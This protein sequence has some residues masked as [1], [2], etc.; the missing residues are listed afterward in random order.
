MLTVT[1]AL[2]TQPSPGGEELER[3]LLQIAQD[4]RQALGELYRLTRGAV[5][6]LALSWLKNAQEAQDVTQ[7]VFVQVWENA[8]QYR[9]QGRPMGW[10][11]TMTKNLTKMRL[12]TQGRVTSLT[13]EEWQAIP[14]NAPAFTGEDRALLQDAMATLSDQERQV[15][16]LH[17]VAGLRHREIGTLLE[18]PLPTVLSKYSRA[19]KKLRRCMEGDDSL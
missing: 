16:L 14:D 5:Y 9:P 10:L 4:D 18:L 11:L 3:L 17:A 19:L 2:T 13:Q 6:A 1:S 8:W 12:R 15:V 7:D